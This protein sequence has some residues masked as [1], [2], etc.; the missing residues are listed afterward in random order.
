MFHVREKL[1]LCDLVAKYSTKSAVCN[2]WNGCLTLHVPWEEVNSWMSCSSYS[3]MMSM[4]SSYFISFLNI[5]GNEKTC[6]FWHICSLHIWG[7]CS[8]CKEW[9]S[10]WVSGGLTPCRQL[11]PSSRR[12]HVRTSNYSTFKL[13]IQTIKQK[14]VRASNYSTFKLSNIQTIN[15]N[16]QTKTVKHSNNS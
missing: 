4:Q 2:I 6:D 11:K 13:S 9:V 12:E 15:S 14:H 8:G 3:S 5:K 16:Y 10:E 7:M 1:I